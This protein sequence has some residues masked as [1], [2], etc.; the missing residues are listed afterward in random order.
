M[1]RTLYG[2]K[3]C[4]TVRRARNDLAQHGIAY[5]FHDLRAEGID[6]GTLNHW[7]S[8]LGLDRVLNRR[9]TTWRQLRT[10]IADPGDE[11]SL[12]ALMQEHPSLIKRPV[13]QR[14]LQ[15]QIGY[16]RP[17]ADQRIA[18]FAAND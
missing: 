11:P 12:I 15:V 8:A 3:N 16:P 4:D 18:W 14:G 10:E 6:R 2:I 13:F 1:E 9:G 7:V 17:E 5:R